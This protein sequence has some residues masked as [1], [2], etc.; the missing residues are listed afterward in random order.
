MAEHLLHDRVEPTGRLVEHQQVGTDHQRRDQDDLLPVAFR[1]SPD[2]L[3]GVEVEPGDQLVSVGLVDLT[4]GSAEEMEGLCPG[5]RGP[6]IC[7]SAHEG[8]VAVGLDGLALAVEPKDPAPAFGGVDEPEEEADGG[9]LPGAVGAQ[10]ADH[11]SGGH[12]EVEVVK[13][14]NIAVALG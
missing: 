4:V 11:L 13:G 2:L 10:V 1:V 6:Q 3:G 9:R 5:E 7:F 8:Q 14:G 12:L